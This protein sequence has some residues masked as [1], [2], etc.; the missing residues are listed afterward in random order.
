M[1]ELPEYVDVAVPVGLRKT[2]A[3]AVPPAMRGRVAPGMRVLVP[4]GRKPLTGYVVGFPGRDAVAGFRLKAV[5][6]LLD[7]TPAITPELV[8]TALWVAEYYFAPPGEVF[9]ALFPAGS[10]TSGGRMTSL[11]PKASTLLLGGLRPSGLR[12]QED[13]LLD[14]LA[15]EG[16]LPVPELVKK[17]GVRGGESWLEPLEA[18]G[19]I[20]LETYRDS[21][22]VK[23]KERLGIRRL[24][25]G[26][27]GTGAASAA[28]DGPPDAVA[29]LPAA[30]MRLYAALASVAG[31]VPLQ[32][33][34]DAAGCARAAAD[35]LA[36]KGLVEIAPLRVERFP[37][38]LDAVGR[39]GRDVTLTRYQ[40]ELIER[41]TAIIRRDG[42]GG[43][44]QAAR[45]L[46][47]GVTGSGKTEVYLHL[48]A[49]ALRLGGTAIFLVPE[50]G[51]TPLLSRQVVSR[52]PGLVALMHSG[53][54]AGERFDQWTRIRDGESKVVVGTRSAVF[55]PLRDLR[56]VII[57]EEQDG[58]YK[59]DETPCYHAREVAWRRLQEA[60]RGGV[61]VTGSATPAVE[62]YFQASRD[63]S[64]FHIPER[65]EARP[66][67][68]VRVVSMV[69]E[70]Q[71]SGKNA[72]LSQ[73]LQDELRSCMERG[74]QAIVLLNRRGFA[75]TILCRSCGHVY[76]CPDCSIS[77]TYHREAGRLV[78]HYCGKE[79]P[80][81][82]RCGECGGAYIHYAGA[83]TEQLEA[84]LRELLP[85]A[86]VARLDRDTTQRRGV[87]RSTL[88]AFSKREID[89]LVGTQ[90]LAKGHDFPAVTLVGVVSADAGL[91]FP[92]FRA[93][94][95]TFQLLTQVAG[96]AGR[97]AS[98]GRVILQSWHPEHYALRFACS[99]DYAGFFRKEI[100]FRK[101]MGYPPYQNLTQILVSDPDESKALRGAGEIADALKQC[102]ARM[103]ERG[104]LRLLGPAAAP[105]EK[106]R[107][108]YRV[109]ILLKG[110]PGAS[111]G[112][113][114]EECFA[115]LEKRRG[116]TRVHRVHIDVDP[117]SLL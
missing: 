46:V 67:P 101:L 35:A 106:L 116:S 69:E 10:E 98:P 51:L 57:D 72:V 21:P 104:R 71:R 43:G 4:F 30:Q 84:L 31:A 78:C 2:F 65:V 1:A 83:G 113:L 37:A 70:F 60:R 90:M 17:A 19:W 75:R 114:L 76:L 107:G 50:I 94:E 39:A 16:P 105:M 95:K 23:A 66:M 11:T 79:A 110:V 49:E 44:G 99:Q 86:R 15:A 8:R 5:E 82:S 92:D 64:C 63:G 32:E 96:R 89:L 20:R 40:R 45:F 102:F 22:K 9:R 52:F 111:P 80:S 42:E 33:I 103:P 24:G 81:P 87:L 97:G 93:A 48:I 28:P 27:P 59:Q 47:H 56:L 74:E 88:L 34:L 117:L 77:M 108:Q 55:A 41:V 36:R 14:V 115:A 109:Q 91:N 58:S 3:Y 26:A 68:E 112:A 25:V 85:Q 38:D 6:D 62:S 73:P 100:E 61:L 18:A 54:S 12:R 13:A 53:M 29:K 7:Q